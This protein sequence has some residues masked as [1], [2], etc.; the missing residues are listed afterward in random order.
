MLRADRKTGVEPGYK[1]EYSV[2]G[3][4]FFPVSW[5][6]CMGVRGG[7]RPSKTVSFPSCVCRVFSVVSVVDSKPVLVFVRHSRRL[8]LVVPGSG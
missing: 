5:F 7:S 6:V 4:G 2:F 1:G 8:G 3:F